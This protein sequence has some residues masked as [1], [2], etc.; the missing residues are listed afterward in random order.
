[1][2]KSGARAKTKE[3]YLGE[4]ISPKMSN[5]GAFLHGHQSAFFIMY[6]MTASITMHS[7]SYTLCLLQSLRTL[8]HVL[9]DCFNHYVLFIM[10]T[11]TF[12]HYLLMCTT[13][14]QF[15]SCTAQCF[16]SHSYTLHP[17][18]SY[19]YCLRLFWS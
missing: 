4:P 13:A 9:Y 2:R 8:H 1:M 10:Y 17:L 5:I 11:M 7:S 6:T 12:N 18:S 19:L 3:L 15:H 16:P 14:F